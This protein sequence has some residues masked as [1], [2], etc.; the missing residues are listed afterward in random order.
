MAHIRQLPS[1]LWRAQVA[2]Q[3]VRASRS[4]DSKDA[5]EAWAKRKE[6]SIIKLDRG[7]AAYG[8]LL[9]SNVPKR[10]ADAISAVPFLATEILEAQITVP[11]TSG[12]Y[13]LIRRDEVVYVGKSVDVFRRIGKHNEDGRDF[14]G[15][16]LLF[17][18]A[19][20]LDELEALYL[21]ALVPPWNQSLATRGRKIERRQTAQPTERMSP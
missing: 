3:G 15:V 20:Q 16:S 11:F 4:F 7:S 17:A 12:I 9:V 19:E 5:A 21:A 10:V 8:A 18:P 14:D 13:F 6:A 1:G 2:R